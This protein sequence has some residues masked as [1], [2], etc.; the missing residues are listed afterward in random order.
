MIIWTLIAS[1]LGAFAG[2]VTVA[3]L[4]AKLFKPNQS[5]EVMRPRDPDMVERLRRE[6]A[7]VP[8]E[9]EFEHQYERP[10]NMDDLSLDPEISQ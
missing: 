7:A 5:F 1:F 10:T 2:V 9:F 3:L 4:M 8:G 6:S